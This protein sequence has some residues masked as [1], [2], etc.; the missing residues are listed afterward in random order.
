MKDNLK[1]YI[2]ELDEETQL[3]MDEY[4][5]RDVA[6]TAYIISEIAELINLD[7]YTIGHGIY[8]DAAHRVKGELYGYSLSNSKEVLTLFYTLYNP[9]A[10]Q[11]IKSLQD[12]EY[13]TAINRLQGFYNAAI[14]GLKF[15]LEDSNDTKSPLYVPAAEIYEN[16]S[17]INTVRLLVLSNSTI[18]KYEIKKQR[19]SGKNSFPDVW[20]LKKIYANLHSG[21][22][23][24]PIDIDFNDEKFSRFKIPFIKMESNDFGYKCVVALF[25]GKL[26]HKLYEEHNTDLLL[27]N[28]R[29]F[30]GFKGSKKTNANI[31]I[32]NTLKEESQMF[33][34]YNNGITALASEIESSS[35]GDKIDVAEDKSG[36]DFISMG[37]LSA[38]RDFRIVNGG[39][40]TAAIFSSKER[41]NVSLFG[42]YVQVKII[43]LSKDIHQVAG[44]ITQYS[45]SQSKIK[46][47]DFTISNNFNMTL[48][49]LSRSVKIPNE[50][51]E[52]IYW[53]F[54]RVRGQYDQE[55]K[56][57]TTKESQAYFN[58]KYPK[59]KKFKKEELAK[60]WKSWQQ[61][62]YDA[63]KG[64]ATNYE[65]FIVKNADFKPDENYYRKS[66]A[67]LIIYRFLMSR[68]E[69][70]Q[71]GNR[72]ATIVTY[73]IAFLNYI[74]FGKLNLEKIWEEQDL[75]PNLKTFLIQL[76]ESI[77]EALIDMAGDIAVLS[78]GKRK[79]S[80]KDLTNYKLKYNLSLLNDEKE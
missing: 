29:Y 9:T 56:Q 54:E 11:G 5:Q 32:L 6:F 74:T 42:V 30:L 73:S 45:N 37:I 60:V 65:M 33:L 28:V 70:K 23:H 20:D 58:M 46:Y 69:N 59:D 68:P 79:Q 25:P 62:P 31:G 75:S 67:L 8:F 64:E 40:T 49:A 80:F 43:V 53:Y 77:N 38:I 17:S 21:L 4:P 66:V 72:K 3:L 12:N 41:N 55:K 63:V 2:T 50:N 10:N 15:D 14:R 26:L 35:L 47:S 27:N 44:K 51:N 34:A 18:N 22:D 7:E 1:A 57:N 16:H 71:Y 36:N 13:Q 48:E 76:C 24:V 19:I 78:W 61:E 52:P 39:Q